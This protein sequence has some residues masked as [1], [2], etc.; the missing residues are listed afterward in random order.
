MLLAVLLS[1]LRRNFFIALQNPIE[2]CN[3]LDIY[4]VFNK[5]SEK[6]IFCV[7]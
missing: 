3:F 6:F 4:I 7:E 2:I 1:P 5:G